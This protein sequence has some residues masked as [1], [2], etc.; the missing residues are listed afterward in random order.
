MGVSPHPAFPK[1]SKAGEKKAAARTATAWTRH[2]TKTSDGARC[3]SGG[4]LDVGLL[5]DGVGLV[6]GA[7]T[8]PL[9]EIALDHFQRLGV[10]ELRTAEISRDMRSSA[11]S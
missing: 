2:S 10:D 1:L 9:G 4:A 6:L 7:A 3:E 11:A 8:R 5:A